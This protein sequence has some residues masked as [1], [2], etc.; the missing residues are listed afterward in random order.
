MNAG[1][2]R[3][4]RPDRLDRRTA[5]LLAVA[6][7]LGP[8]LVAALRAVMPTFSAG[9]AHETAL[10][11]A[12]HPGRQSLTVWLGIAALAMLVPGVLAAARLTRD[13]APRLTWWA[14]GLLV[15]AYTY[16]GV[17]VAG[18]AAAWSAQGAGIGTGAVTRVLDTTHPAVGIAMGVFI[19]GHVVGTV[20]LGVALAQSQRVPAAFG[21]LL[22]L[23]QPLH[24]VAFVILDFRPLDVTA[25]TLT[26]VGMA[27]AAWAL[28]READGARVLAS[29]QTHLAGATA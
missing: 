28:V 15:P 20:L 9:D 22:A 5:T 19:A 25:W 3:S 29:S 7:P 18:D 24:F 17:L 4:A 6:M 2:S 8:L 23:S 1:A 21:W 26:G 27:A 12:A 16:L 13:A 14:V 11:V 10:A